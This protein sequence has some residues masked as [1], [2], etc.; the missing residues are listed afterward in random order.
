MVNFPAHGNTVVTTGFSAGAGTYTITVKVDEDDI[1]METDDTNN[2]DSEV[3]TFTAC[4]CGIKG[5][6]N[7]DESTDPLDVTYLVNFVY[8][9]QDALAERPNCPHPKG[10]MNCDD[11]ADPLDVT[12][13]V[14]YVYLSQDALCDGCAPSAAASYIGPSMIKE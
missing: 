3:I 10:D 13:L 14:N 12:Y 11:S 2:D 9:S 7:D 1:K 8:L 5:D 4:D 6:V